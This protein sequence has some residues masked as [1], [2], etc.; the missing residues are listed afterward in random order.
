MS[1]GEVDIKLLIGG[2]QGGGIESAGQIVLKS[3]ILKG[4]HVIGT[5]EYQSNIIG[6]HSYFTVRAKVERPGAIN[7]PV[8]AATLLDAE[9]IFTHFGDV[10]EEGILVYDKGAVNTKLH[11][12][13]PMPKPLKQRLA[14]LFQEKGLEPVAGSALRLAE[15]R[16]VRLIGM[17]MRDLVR[18]VAH[19]SQAPLSRAGKTINTMGLAA[20]LFLRG[21]EPSWI[22]KAINLHFAAKRKV[23]EMNVL[24]A[25]LA[26]E[27]VEREYGS[28]CCFLPEGPLNGRE[29]MLVT[30]NEI[31]AIGKTVGGLTMQTYYPITPASDEAL[32]LEAHRNLELAPWAEEALALK[33]IGQVVLQTEDE[34]SAI[35]SALGAAAAGAR[36][37]TSTSGPGFA[38]MNEAISLAIMAELPVVI[39]VWM[40]GGPST[41]LPTREG[42]QDLLHALFSGHGD[43]PKIVVASGDHVEAYFDAIK[44]LNWAEKYQ[45]PV[46]HLVDKYLA[47]TLTSIL[48]EEIDPLKAKLDRGKLVENP[49][50]DYVRYK[51][52]EDGISP[53]APMGKVPLVVT[54][55]EHTED[56][57]PTEDPV[58]REEMVAKRR[59]K[60]ETIARE[61]PSSEKVV[62]HG[63][64]D[65]KITIVSWGSTKP[66]ILEALKLLEAEGIHANFLQIRLFYPFPV[67]EVLD[68]L[69]RSELVIDVEQNDLMQAA[70]VIRGFT[71]YTINHFVKKITGRALWD[72]EVA[73]A[74]K[75]IVEN[76]DREVVVSGGA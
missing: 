32:F 4:Y 22:E 31:V 39:T 6:A 45:T 41:G 9:S 69:T 72:T 67:R 12:I 17:P 61:I 55:L 63:D 70:F 73:W 25:R 30:G 56:G 40:R 54:G 53:R 57:M 64:P 43:N 76:G 21:V 3:L 42:Q 65:A 26:I 62:L 52:T 71:G 38:L 23:A 13:A 28:P 19:E 8:D 48:R 18:K 49:G 74:V 60:F 15:E 7:F 37:A 20:M 47:S 58:A 36:V 33:S 35:M 24:A 34:L 16:G 46:I 27:Y 51:I 29:V 59:R 11:L 14:R 75:R 10:K 2:P 1:N 68:V 44:A 66:I 5:R 50:P